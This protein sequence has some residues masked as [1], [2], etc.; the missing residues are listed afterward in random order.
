[1]LSLGVMMECGIGTF[2]AIPYSAATAGTGCLGQFLSHTALIPE[3]YK[4]EFEPPLP[5]RHE[6][7]DHVWTMDYLKGM[8]H[9]E[10]RQYCLKLIEDHLQGKTSQYV[11]ELQLRCKDGSYK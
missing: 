9:P 2:K 7:G 11:C 3:L 10:E 8:M 4:P 6:P 1:M 5:T